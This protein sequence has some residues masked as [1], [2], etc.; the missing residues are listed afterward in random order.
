M[1]LEKGSSALRIPQRRK[2]ALRVVVKRGQ[3]AQ[4]MRNLPDLPICD[5]LADG[6]P[7]ASSMSKSAG[8]YWITAD[9]TQSEEQTSGQSCVVLITK[10]HPLIDALGHPVELMLSRETI[11]PV[12]SRA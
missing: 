3:M 12:Q 1:Y 5:F 9:A 8:G 11:S 4:L 2:A 10:V 7:Q 6:R